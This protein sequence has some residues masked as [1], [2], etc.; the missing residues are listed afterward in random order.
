MAD[1]VREA[2]YQPD[3]PAW[4][5]VHGLTPPANDVRE[6]LEAAREAE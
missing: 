4:N 6:A 1:D 2:L 5:E 3:A